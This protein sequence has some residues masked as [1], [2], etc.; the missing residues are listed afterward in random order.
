MQTQQSAY[1]TNNKDNFGADNIVYTAKADATA[2]C[3]TRVHSDSLSAW[4]T[5]MAL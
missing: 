5:T 1:K 3:A 4:S 2:V